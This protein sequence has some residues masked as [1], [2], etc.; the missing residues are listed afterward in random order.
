MSVRIV[1]EI[2]RLISCE[3]YYWSINP[4]IYQFPNRVRTFNYVQYATDHTIM[5]F[6]RLVKESLESGLNTLFDI[7]DL[8]LALYEAKQALTNVLGKFF[9]YFTS[10][11]IILFRY[12]SNAMV[13]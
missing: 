1:V 7:K 8:V 2:D 4:F 12:Q 10:I 9:F 5:P 6:G 3:S 13:P 11:S